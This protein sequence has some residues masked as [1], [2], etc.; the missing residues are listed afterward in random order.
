MGDGAGIMKYNHI[1]KY[2]V[3]GAPNALM[4]DYDLTEPD[5][6]NGPVGMPDGYTRWWNPTEFP[7]PGLFGY[8]PPLGI[9]PAYVP[10]ATLNPYKYFGDGLA[11]V[12]NLWEFLT[13][14]TDHGVF[15]SGSENTRNY[16]IRFPSPGGIKFSYAIVANWISP[17]THPANAPEAVGLKVDV[18]PDVF[19][20][21]ATNNGGDLILDVSVFDWDSEPD[22][23]VMMDYR[24]IVESTVL[25][26]PYYTS[27]SEMTP[28]D[29]GD[30]YYTYHM[31]IPADNVGSTAGN[32]FWVIVECAD[33]N[34]SNPYDIHNEAWNDK[35]VACFRYDLY[36]ATCEYGDIDSLLD[37]ASEV[38]GAH[39]TV[40]EDVSVAFKSH[41]SSDSLADDLDDIVDAV[42]FADWGPPLSVYRIDIETIPDQTALEEYRT[43]SKDYIAEYVSECD[44]LYY[45]NWVPDPA[46]G[47]DPF[48]T[49][50][51]VA[52]D[53]T[54]R[55]EPIL[56]TTVSPTKDQETGPKATGSQ[57]AEWPNKLGVVKG[58]AKVTIQTVGANGC[59]SEFIGSFTSSAWFPYVIEPA[60]ASPAPVKFCWPKYE[61]MCGPKPG[62]PDLMECAVVSQSYNF[63]CR[64]GVD[65]VNVDVSSLGDT[66]QAWACADG[67]AG[68]GTGQ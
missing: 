16:Y 5:A 46:T 45:V 44:S 67:Q 38:V 62:V 10:T 49:L 30:D 33:E 54:V 15:A 56:D 51:V 53:G 63:I 24:I 42:A 68:A 43:M 55:Y 31:E 26:L 27:A 41:V 8:T 58:W 64:I 60:S 29:S 20:T 6:H 23:D 11:T 19:Y 66:V 2:A 3:A 1:L 32:E 59:Q 22:G 34:Y 21:D 50:A 48:R 65:P 37:M 35:L 52:P 36:V 13:T 12:G 18:T 28:V 40:M 17:T 7:N 9:S 39:S 14:S 61:C 4:Y 47:A 25:G 57:R